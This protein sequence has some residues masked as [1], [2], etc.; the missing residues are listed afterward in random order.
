MGNPDY[1]AQASFI[2]VILLNTGFPPCMLHPIRHKVPMPLEL[3]LLI[4]L[5]LR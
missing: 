4:P 1:L 3:K 2:P 5:R